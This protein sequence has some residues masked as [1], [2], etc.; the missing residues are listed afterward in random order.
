L[1]VTRTLSPWIAACTLSFDSFE[2]LADLA[3]G[4]V[5]RNCS[6]RAG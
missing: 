4:L 6:P 2:T 1:P 5:D 3:I